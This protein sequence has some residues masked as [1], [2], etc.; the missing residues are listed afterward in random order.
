[1]SHALIYIPYATPSQVEAT[2]KNIGE[3]A[4][5]DPVLVT[6]NPDATPLPGYDILLSEGPLG[7]THWLRTIA[8]HI[9]TIM[10]DGFFLYTSYRTLSPGSFILDRYSK[11]MQWW[12]ADMGYSDYRLATRDGS[13]T[14]IPLLDMQ[15]GSVRDDFD[16]G[17]LLILRTEQFIE[18]V[19]NWDTEYKYAGLYAMRLAIMKNIRKVMHV[20]EPLYTVYEH[21]DDDSASQFDYVDPRNRE[22][23][24]E[25]EYAFTDFLQ[26]TKG[27]ISWDKDHIDPKG[28]IFEY[29]AS[30]IIPVRNR[31]KTIADAIESVLRQKTDF[32]FNVIVVDN[33]STD[34]TTEVVGRYACKDNRVIHVVPKQDDLSIG[35]CWNLASLQPKCGKFML[36]LDSDD[37]YSHD[38]VVQTI[39]D[40]FYK[41]RCAML[42]GSYMLTDFNLNTIP[43]GIIDHREWTDT[44]GAN[45]ALRINGFGAP[46]CFYTPVFKEYMLPNTGYG[47]DYAMGL[48]I[49]RHYH[50]GRIYDV[51]YLCR[52]WEDNSDANLDIAR[53]NANNKYKD[54]I[55]TV[56]L[57]ARRKINYDNEVPF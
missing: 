4:D 40:E 27:W 43:P 36:Q 49:S 55:R 6:D 9:E 15:E 47:E 7:S 46:R 34:G 26:D 10:P 37:L 38:T 18:I 13:L 35:G 33:K 22:R 41:Q 50:I 44:N 23:Q 20:D 54:F 32:K 42:V 28:Q 48:M 21:T 56:E 17:S 31:V 8:K 14:R 52:R 1:M 24:V 39:V 45:N 2:L 29:E 25:M 5:L 16:C 11:L 53:L 57:K 30:V 3:V 19:D 12:Q 51:L